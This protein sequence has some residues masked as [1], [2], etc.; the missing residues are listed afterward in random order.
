M[1][2]VTIFLQIKRFP[3][4]MYTFAVRPTTRKVDI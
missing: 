2:K 1:T 3:E 4:N